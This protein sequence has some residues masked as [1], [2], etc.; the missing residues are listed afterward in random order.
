MTHDH[1]RAFLLAIA[2]RHKSWARRWLKVNG[3]WN[4]L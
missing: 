4:Y 2:N 1:K 3:H